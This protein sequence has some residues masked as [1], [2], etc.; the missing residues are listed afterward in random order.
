[1]KRKEFLLTLI[2]GAALSPLLA[3]NATAMNNN[4]LQFIQL[5]RHATMTLTMNGRKILID[6]MLSPK[7]AMDPVQNAGN[8]L[9]IPMVELP[10]TPEE[11]TSQLSDLDAVF[12]THTHRDHW[13]DAAINMLDKGT[14]IFCQPPD[15]EKIQGAGFL[16]VR[17]IDK[18]IEWGGM[19]IYRTKGRHGTGEIGQKMGEVSG[20]VFQINTTTVYLAGDTIWC[21]EVEEALKK[22]HPDVVVLNTGGAKFLTGGPITMTPADVKETLRHTGEAVVVAVHMDTIN[23]CVV[24]RTDLRDSLKTTG[25]AGKVFIPADGEQVAF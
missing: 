22:H 24:K 8:T 17:K 13:D 5:W 19:K 12:V 21:P 25:D 18:E 7:D 23:H 1:M 4:N 10:F 11:L 2:K 15:Y 9:R 14:P 20:F 16:D 3:A 6:P